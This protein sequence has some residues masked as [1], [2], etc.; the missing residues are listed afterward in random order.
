MVDL[1]TANALAVVAAET[2][3]GIAMV[4]DHLQAMPGRALRSDGVHDPPRHRGRR[5]DRGAPVP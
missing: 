1:H 2:G 4:G 5:T 3:A